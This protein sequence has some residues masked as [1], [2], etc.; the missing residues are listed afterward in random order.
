MKRKR[1]VQHKSPTEYQLSEEHDDGIL[2]DILTI[3]EYA[4]L[5]PSAPKFFMEAA[6]SEQDFRHAMNKDAMKLSRRE[7]ALIH[8][9]NYLGLTFAFLIGIAGMAFSYFLIIQ[10]KETLGSIFAGVTLL[11]LAGLFVRAIAPK[12]RNSK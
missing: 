4:K 10:D 2:P 3:S 11:G 8:G 5:D 7:Q 6:K 9:I 1:S 12:N